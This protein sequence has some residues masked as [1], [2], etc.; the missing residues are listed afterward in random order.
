MCCL[1]SA[2]SFVFFRFDS[3]LL[4][5]RWIHIIKGINGLAANYEV[6]PPTQFL[7]RHCARFPKNRQ[8]RCPARCMFALQIG[9]LIQHADTSM[10][11]VLRLCISGRNAMVYL[12]HQW[13]PGRPATKRRG[14]KKLS[15][16]RRWISITFSGARWP[17]WKS[18]TIRKTS[19]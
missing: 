9:L 8:Y 10:S 19:C 1:S 6:R 7:D 4:V 15:V 18:N 3:C 16:D 17:Y 12:V 13:W 14:Q 2:L 11:T 5:R